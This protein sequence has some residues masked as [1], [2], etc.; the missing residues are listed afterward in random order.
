MKLCQFTTE[1]LIKRV[2]RSSSQ[3]STITLTID[4]DVC[5]SMFGHEGKRGMLVWQEIGND[6]QPIATKERG[7]VPVKNSPFDK[8][9]AWAEINPRTKWLIERCKDRKFARFLGVQDGFMTNA[10]VELEVKALVIVTLGLNQSRSE[11]ELDKNREKFNSL[12]MDYQNWLSNLP[13]P[14]F[15]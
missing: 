4:D 5:N 12:R 10:Q 9:A 8:S 7:P 15:S 14:E 11:V 13:M 1:S 6:E 2:N 3:G